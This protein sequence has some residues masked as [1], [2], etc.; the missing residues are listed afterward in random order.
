MSTPVYLNEMVIDRKVE[1]TAVN[2][3]NGN[4]YTQRNAVLFAAKDKCLIPTLE[5][6]LEENIK[7]GADDA[8]V[9]S[10]KDLISR[11]KSFQRNIECKVPDVTSDCEVDMLL[12][13]RDDDPVKI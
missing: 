11:V 13:P 9:E 12:K 4:I 1:M 10:V 8:Q 7:E 6:Y 2:P 5:A 3:C